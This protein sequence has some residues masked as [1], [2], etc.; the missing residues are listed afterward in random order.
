MVNS[1]SQYRM[2]F[3][4]RVAGVCAVLVL[5]ISAVGWALVHHVQDSLARIDVFSGLLGRP[6]K[7]ST[8]TNYLLVGSDTR[9]GLSPADLRALHAGSVESATGARSDTVILAHVSARRDRVTLVSF[10]RDSYLDIPPYTGKDNNWHAGYQG[11]LNS[12]Y[13][14]GGPKLTVAT[15]EQNTGIRIDHYV[16][17]NFVSFVTVVNAL[18]GVDVCTPT[19]IHDGK[20]GLRLPAGVTHLNGAQSLAYVRARYSLGDG[21]DLGRINRQ[22]DFIAALYHAA[23]SGDTLLNPLRLN[24]ALSASLHALR[25]DPGL[26][27]QDLASLAVKLRGVSANQVQLAT[28]P[29]SSIDY[30]VAGWGSTVLWDVAN[31]PR[32]FAAIG[33]DRPVPDLIAQPTTPTP[34]PAAS[35][36]DTDAPAAGP[37]PSPSAKPTPMSHSAAVARCGGS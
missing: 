13:A 26:R 17:L 23:T 3:L 27:A 8:A 30:Q 5:L 25:T 7:H 34:T 31:A 37:A 16:E 32:L 20:S 18:G 2:S 36:P 24:R 12:A 1:S 14:E 4:T 6:A 22:Q 28:V 19:P 35:G 9:D 21:S 15:I 10:P 29:L 33:S 11:K